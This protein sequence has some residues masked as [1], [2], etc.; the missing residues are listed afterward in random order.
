MMT[1]IDDKRTNTP[2]P[3]GLK[4]PWADWKPQ[5]NGKKKTPHDLQEKH[6][7][8]ESAQVKLTAERR[9]HKSQRRIVDAR[10]WDGMAPA[11]Q[12]AALEIA[13]AHDMMAA[14]SAM[15]RATGSASPAAAAR[16][17][18]RKCTRA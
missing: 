10:L 13:A 16:A 17:T 2:A 18:S 5:W 3:E 11:Q 6:S 8:T 9:S 1:V 14:A 15:C 7:P 12:D 4:D